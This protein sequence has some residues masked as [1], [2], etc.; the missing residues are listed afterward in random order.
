[1]ARLSGDHL[2]SHFSPVTIVRMGGWIAVL[3][4]LLVVTAHH[5][6]LTLV[7]FSVIGLGLAN[8]IPIAFS[9]AGNFPGIP[10]GVGIAA[11]ATIGYAGFLASPPLV[12]FLAEATSLRIAFASIIVLLAGLPLIAHTVSTGKPEKQP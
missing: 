1:V 4:F 6:A 5:V 11:V 3:G 10:S 8:I 12:G 9:A 2:K 7:G